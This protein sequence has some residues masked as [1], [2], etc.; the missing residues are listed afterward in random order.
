MGVI[1]KWTEYKVKQLLFWHEKETTA[2]LSRRL[3]IS[4]ASITIKKL[5]LGIGGNPNAWSEEEEDMLKSLDGQTDSEA[6]K[7]MG[8]SRSSIYKKRKRLG[9]TV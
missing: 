3:K 5:E 7:I 9:I 4:R 6:A 1:T 8:R 2:E